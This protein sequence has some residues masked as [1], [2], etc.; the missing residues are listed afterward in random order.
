MSA[1]NLY[2][3]I[4][5][6]SNKIKIIEVALKIKIWLKKILFSPYVK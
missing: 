3:T 2:L 6:V 4:K 1:I 5:V